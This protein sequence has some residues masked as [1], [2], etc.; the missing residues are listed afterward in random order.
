MNLVD[1]KFKVRALSENKHTFYSYNGKMTQI[2][3]QKKDL[4]HAKNVSSNQTTPN[5]ILL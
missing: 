1:Q 5:F 3:I 4:D 2:Q